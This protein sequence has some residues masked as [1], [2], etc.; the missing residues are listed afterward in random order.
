MWHAMWIGFCNGLGFCLAIALTV[1]FTELRAFAK[2]NYDSNVLGFIKRRQEARTQTTNQAA[3]AAQAAT[4]STFVPAATV[5]ANEPTA[6]EPVQ[7]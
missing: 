4:P 7:H 6:G 5:P 1:G 2:R 3:Q